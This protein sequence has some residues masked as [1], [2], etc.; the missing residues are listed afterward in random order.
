MC[1]CVGVRACVC[2]CVCK[3]VCVC[4]WVGGWVGGG[5]AAHP[6]H[7][8]NAVRFLDL[9]SVRGSGPQ[10]SLERLDQCFP[11]QH[12]TS[13][14]SA[15]ELAFGYHDKDDQQ[16]QDRP[17]HHGDPHSAPVPPADVDSDARS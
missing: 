16:W 3:C 13:S 14:P 1:V 2:V 8:G 7:E 4:V 15:R 11:H 12:D 17:R 9:C 6:F 5:G 10:G